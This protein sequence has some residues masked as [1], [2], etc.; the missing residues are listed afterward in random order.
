MTKQSLKK[1]IDDLESR[2]SGKPIQAVWMDWDDPDVWHERIAQ[3]GQP[4]MT[5]DEV[6]AKY[7]DHTLLVVI[8]DKKPIG[9]EPCDNEN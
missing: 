7:K 6:E 3:Q 5:W 8:Y 2:R 9:G 1:R 4:G